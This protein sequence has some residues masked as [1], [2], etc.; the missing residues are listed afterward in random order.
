MGFAWGYGVIGLGFLFIF[1]VVS[2]F[3]V[4]ELGGDGD[5]YC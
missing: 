1:G 2:S 3:V 4:Y 5:I